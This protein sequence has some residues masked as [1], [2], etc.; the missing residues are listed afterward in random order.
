MIL[1]TFQEGCTEIISMDANFG[2]RRKKTSG[3]SERPPLNKERFFEDQVQVDKFVQSYKSG[4]S[5][6][7]SVCKK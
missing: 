7:K 2:L 3:M 4:S 5:S 1:I 6:S